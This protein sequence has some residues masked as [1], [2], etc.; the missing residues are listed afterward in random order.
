MDEK[1]FVPRV[2]Y[3]GGLWIGMIVLSGCLLV[4]CALMA[5]LTLAVTGVD[6]VW[7]NTLVETES[8]SSFIRWAFACTAISRSLTLLVDSRLSK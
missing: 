5:G 3:S 1:Y 6:L 8:R 2:K 4:I 7:V